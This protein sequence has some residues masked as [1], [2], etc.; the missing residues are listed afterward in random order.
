MYKYCIQPSFRFPGWQGWF[1]LCKTQSLTNTNA[2]EKKKKQARKKEIFLFC[3][4]RQDTSCVEITE[5]L[6]WE[7]RYNLDT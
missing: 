7:K 1:G 2:N 6:Y 3:F 5:G 4:P